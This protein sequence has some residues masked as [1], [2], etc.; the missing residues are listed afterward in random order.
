MRILDASTGKSIAN[1]AP[2]N[3]APYVHPGSWAIP[4]ARKL[5]ISQLPKGAYRLEVQATDSAG[6][7]TPWYAA[8]FSI[9]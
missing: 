3:A 1:F 7:T 2:L 8:D 4:L 6:R 5:P 9:K